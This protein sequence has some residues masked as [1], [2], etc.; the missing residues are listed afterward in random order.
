MTN[1]LT[2]IIGCYATG[3]N[4]RFNGANLQY[5]Y[6]NTIPTKVTATSTYDYNFEYLWSSTIKDSTFTIPSMFGNIQKLPTYYAQNVD[7]LN[8]NAALPLLL[9]HMTLLDFTDRKTVKIEYEYRPEL[10]I[11][12]QQMVYPYY[13]SCI[14]TTGGGKAH[15]TELI[16]GNKSPNI[17][18]VFI[19]SDNDS[20]ITDSNVMNHNIKQSIIGNNANWWSQSIEQ[21]GLVSYGLAE[22][23]GSFNLPLYI[24]VHYHQIH[25]ILQQLMILHN[26]LLQHG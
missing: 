16:L 13:R 20:H 6:D 15:N 14:D 26:Q 24:Q 7:V 10:C 23:K 21:W 12:N 9:D 4:N 5:T 25:H 8:N 19:T 2:V 1:S 11:L 17:T 3:L 18:S 22:N